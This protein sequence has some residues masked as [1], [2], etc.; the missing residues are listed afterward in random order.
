MNDTGI[1]LNA[2]HEVAG[3]EPT[4]VVEG[5]STIR[6]VQVSHHHAAD[7]VIGVGD[8]GAAGCRHAFG[9]GDAHRNAERDRL[10][11]GPGDGAVAPAPSI[12]LRGEDRPGARQRPGGGG[13]LGQRRDGRLQGVEEGLV[14][15]LFRQLAPSVE[16]LLGHVGDLQAGRIRGDQRALATVLFEPREEAALDVE[17]FHHDLDDPIAFGQQVKIVRKITDL[18]PGRVLFLHK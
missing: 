2:L 17:V 10:G 16:F 7:H 5:G 9:Q 3:V 1:A 18:N 8:S 14:G 11:H 6:I 4:I 15:R 13:S 12:V